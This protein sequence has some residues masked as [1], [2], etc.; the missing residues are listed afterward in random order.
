VPVIAADIKGIFPDV[1]VVADADL[2][3]FIDTANLIVTENLANTNPVLSVERKFRI[4][5]YLAAH[6][7]AIAY[8]RG[9]L[10]RKRLG[11]ADESYGTPTQAMSV[12][13]GSTRFGMQALALDTT[14]TLASLSASGG[15]KAEFEVV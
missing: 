11:E 7:A 14:G 1:K 15:L 12:G 3:I 2:A 8:E 9:Q 5:L 10:T 4:S 13:L 6:F